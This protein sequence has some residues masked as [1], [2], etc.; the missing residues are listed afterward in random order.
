MSLLQLVRLFVIRSIRTERFLTSLSIIGVALGIG[1]FTSIR[2]ASDRAISSFES[3]IR[4]LTPYTEYEIT[5]S[6]GIDFDERI[7]ERVRSLAEDSFPVLKAS[8]YFPSLGESLDINGVYTIKTLG[9]LRPA[10]RQR[11]DTETFFRDLNGIIITKHFADAHSL[12][13]GDSLPAQVYD[14]LH[15]LKVVD[16]IDAPSVPSNAVIMDIGNFQESFALTGKLSRIDVAADET[17]AGRIRKILPPGLS[18]EK[19]AQVIENRKSLL[20]SFRYNLE[21]VGLI[22]I[23]VGVFLLYNTV[24]ITV[25]KKRTEIGILRGLGAGRRTVVLLFVIQ[26]LFLGTIGSFLG[27]GIGQAFA[28]V[29][30]A[31]V[32]KTITS[33]Y[34][35]V[36]IS[37]YLIT[38]AEAFSALLLGVVISLAAS[39][40]PAYESS[41]IL[42]TESSRE[43][44][45]EGRRRRRRGLF[46]CIGF[47]IIAV[48]MASAYLDYRLMPFPFPFLAYAGILLIILGFTLVS[49]VYLSFFIRLMERPVG[50][51]FGPAGSIASADMQGS[52]YRFSVALMSV[53]ISSSLIVSLLIVIVSFRNSLTRWINQNISADVYIKPSSCRSNF[54]FFPLSPDLVQTLQRLPGVAGIDRF[55]TLEIG[56][57]G[58]KIVAGFGDTEVARTFS[59]KRHSGSAARFRESAA[60]REAGISTYIATKYGLKKGDALELQTPRGPVRFLIRDVFSSYSTTSGFIYMDRRWLDEYWGLDDAT[61]LGLYVGEGVDISRFIRQ[62]QAALSPRYSL[63]IMNTRELRERV[64]SIFNRTFAITYAIELIAVAVALIGVVNT[65]FSLVL[66]RRREISVIRYLGGSWGQ[67]RRMLILSAGIVGITG[68]ILGSVIGGIMSVIFIEVINKVSFGWQIDLDVPVG[69]LSVVSAALFLTTLLAGVLPARVARKIDPKKFISFE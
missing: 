37:D 11:F 32:Q 50:T 39:V 35:A 69:Y 21:F 56:Y 26:G 6:A 55:R 20:A 9:F 29:S 52:I 16:I 2:V 36:T 60:R 44:S 27:I 18:L 19:K 54:C 53:A 58:K 47:I 63:D 14:S 49:P 10:H 65:L 12:K 45:F 48:G 28:Y 31:A 66:E 7:Y 41:R 62:L 40:I 23:L 25:V 46:S 67:I 51:T 68:I 57:G 64:L 4:S 22:A 17:T 42:P 61:Q 34:S 33:M 59:Q 15:E 24:F 8:A 38:P 30:V 13:K 5:H 1:L 3:D 43:G